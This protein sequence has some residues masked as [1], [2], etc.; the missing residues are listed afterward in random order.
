[1]KR[2]QRELRWGAVPNVRDLGGL[3][4]S[5][6][7]TRF[8]RVARSPRREWFDDSAWGAARSWG[9]RTVVDLRNEDEVGRQD[10]D[11]AVDSES[12]FF[13][14]VSAPTEDHTNE[15]FRE[16][17]FPILDSPEYWAH[18]LRILPDM[19]RNT[20][21]TIA[22]AEPGVL[23]HCS[24]GR[25]RTGLISALLL[26]N[27]G[28]WP[29]AVA[30]DYAMSVCAMA[31]TASHS[32][33]QDR[34]ASWN[35]SQLSAWLAVVHPIALTFATEVAHHLDLIGL[36]PVVRARLRDLLTQ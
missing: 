35:E 28:V 25:D 14:V 26:G 8:G 18:N 33:T 22:W 21:E 20:L 13:T 11:P 34:Q 16:V 9:L 4:T 5:S 12:T 31:G 3:P 10:G 30:E 19:V 36:D 23:V 17:C 2:G 6:G 24:A 32:P 7:E 27:A 1:M 29:E 15:D